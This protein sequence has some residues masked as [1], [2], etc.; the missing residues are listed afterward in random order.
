MISMIMSY[1]SKNKRT[2][3]AKEEKY[4]SLKLKTFLLLHV[5]V[6]VME[7]IEKYKRKTFI[8]TAYILKRNIIIINL[9]FQK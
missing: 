3:K 4:F 1:L 8:Y 5:N 2:M 7:Y 6:N 9:L